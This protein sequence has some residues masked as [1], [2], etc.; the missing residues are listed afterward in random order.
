VALGIACA[1]GGG[2]APRPVASP[3]PRPE[4]SVQD[5]YESGRYAEV[6]S[7]VNAAPA[8]EAGPEAVWLAAHSHLRLGQRDEAARGF[9]TLAA[10][11]GSPAWQAAS[12]LAL[13]GLAGGA[14]P[15][16]QAM[17]AAG[18]FPGD[19][20]VQYELGLARARRN[21]FAGAAEALDRSIE[22]NPGFAYA[23]YHAGLAHN[24][25]D[26]VDL[27]ASRL[28]TFLRLAPDAPERPEVE[29]ILRT[30]RGL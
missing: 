22:T 18:A 21:D 30:L 2:G 9:Q 16:D 3:P 4:G 10:T 24:R 17:D 26:R 8:A 15:L 13:A 14:E 23:Y 25:L 7:R 5:L 29:A 20:F 1:S 6:V 27:M 11:T 12:Q 28:E 19:W